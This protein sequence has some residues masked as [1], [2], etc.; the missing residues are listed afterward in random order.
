MHSVC[1]RMLWPVVRGRSLRVITVYD[2][3]VKSPE[4]GRSLQTIPATSGA[5][6]CTS[7]KSRVRRQAIFVSAAERPAPACRT[8]DEL[9]ELTCFDS[10]NFLQRFSLFPTRV[11]TGSLSAGCKINTNSACCN[12]PSDELTIA[13]LA[14]TCCPTPR[15]RSAFFQALPGL[16]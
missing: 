3:G 9:P 4:S 10:D 6:C 11:A 15:R 2:P 14:G 7:P 13:S 5:C 1:H 8:A 12:L 16:G